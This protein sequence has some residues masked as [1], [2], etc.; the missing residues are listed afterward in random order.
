M[1]ANQANASGQGDRNLQ[2]KFPFQE[3]APRLYG[4]LLKKLGNDADASDLVQ[5]TYLRFLRVRK[6]KVIEKPEAYLFRIATNLV[7][8]LSLHQK[9]E[10]TLVD[11]DASPLAR[12]S[13]TEFDARMDRRFEL[14]RLDE[15]LAD[16]PP[17][18]G[19]IL[20]MS[21][22]D[23]FTRDEIAEQLGISPHTVKKYLTKAITACRLRLAEPNS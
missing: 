5:E 22:R 15:V 6:D 10:P 20:I 17:L 8:E 23:G 13:D 1:G 9:R 16:L 2:R 12:L 21:K 4:L 7:Y 14:N 19:K 11:D 3:F 18:Q